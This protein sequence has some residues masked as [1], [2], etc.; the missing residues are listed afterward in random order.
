MIQEDEQEINIS[1]G[2]NSFCM[3][4]FSLVDKR[5]SCY[6]Y[7]FTACVFSIRL[8]LSQIMDRTYFIRSCYA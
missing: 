2:S 1:Y 5:K 7:Y 3:K 6:M 4:N 8:C